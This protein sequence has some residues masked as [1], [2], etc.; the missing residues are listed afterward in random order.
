MNYP[1]NPGVGETVIVFGLKG[2]YIIFAVTAI[3]AFIVLAAILGNTDIPMLLVIL[4]LIIA[5][6]IVLGGIIRIN[7]HYGRYGLMKLYVH[8]KLPE[9]IKNTVEINHIITKRK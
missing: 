5:I 6:S 2:Q 1:S 8:Y 4:I 7:K 9:Y 3:I